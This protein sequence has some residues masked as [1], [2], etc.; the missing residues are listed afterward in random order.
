[1]LFRSAFG[2][3]QVGQRAAQTLARQFGTLDALIET[4]EETLT[5]VE[6]IG[7]QKLHIHAFDNELKFIRYT[8]Q[9]PYP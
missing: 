7:R 8:V 4:D 6:D 2:I 1:M 3:R 9:I 5:E